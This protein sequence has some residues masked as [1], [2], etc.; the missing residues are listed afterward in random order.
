MYGRG[1][2]F[3]DTPVKSHD[4]TQPNANGCRHMFIVCVALG[5][6]EHLTAATNEKLGPSKGFHS[7]LGTA[8]KVNEYIIDRW[9][10]AKPVLLITYK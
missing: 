4:Y 2:Y 9:G 1:A 10:Q 8:G 3:A 7:I 5:N 6:Q